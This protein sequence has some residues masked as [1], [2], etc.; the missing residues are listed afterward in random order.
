VKVLRSLVFWEIAL[1][2]LLIGGLF[3]FRARYERYGIPQNGMYPGLPAKS[4][5]W[6]RKHPYQSVGDVQRGDI[7]IY[8]EQTPQGPYDLVWRV[9]GLPGERIA[10]REDAVIIN[11]KP[12]ARTPGPDEGE[13][14][15]FEETAG[16]FT[17]RIA[18]PRRLTR[19]GDFPETTVPVGHVFVLGDNRPDARDSRFTGP[20]KFEKIVA[21]VGWW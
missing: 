15:L 2:V 8:R 18:V 1:A 5:F 16:E 6:A 13:L 14:R 17:Y 19:D 9:I 3:V 21:R 20:V 4:T 7:I 10:L 11:G 12:L